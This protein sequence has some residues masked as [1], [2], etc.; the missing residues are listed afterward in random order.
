MACTLPE[1]AAQAVR[2]C[3]MQEQLLSCMRSTP[4]K[5]SVLQ[6]A[7]TAAPLPSQLLW[8]A[9]LNQ[10]WKAQEGRVRRLQDTLLTRLTYPGGLIERSMYSK[11]WGSSHS[12]WS[13]VFI[14]PGVQEVLTNE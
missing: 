2:G 9:T 12:A 3:S 6:H 11:V 5:L 7:K 13:G 10:F 14:F 1:G 8:R 4:Y